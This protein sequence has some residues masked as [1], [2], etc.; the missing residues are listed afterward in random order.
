MKKRKVCIV[1]LILAIIALLIGISYLVQGIYARGLGGVNYGSVIF[2]LLVGV[3][4][5][6]FMKK[7]WGLSSFL[8]KFFRK[9]FMGRGTSPFVE[10]AA[11]KLHL[12][13]AST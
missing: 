2:P 9:N 1:I 3:I 10:L 11:L 7:N 4:A 12:I 6:Y 5:V 13:K 8:C